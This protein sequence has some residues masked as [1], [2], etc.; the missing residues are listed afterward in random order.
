MSPAVLKLVDA[1]VTE[2][3]GLIPDD[4]DYAATLFQ[5]RESRLMYTAEYCMEQLVNGGGG[6][7][8]PNVEAVVK[9]ALRYLQHGM[10]LVAKASE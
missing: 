3:C 2:L 7:L 9:K 1:T 8:E 10:A 4:D 6:E 5:P